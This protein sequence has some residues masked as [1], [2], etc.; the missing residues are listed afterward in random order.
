MSTLYP[1]HQSVTSTLASITRAVVIEHGWRPGTDLE[2]NVAL[3]LSHSKAPPCEQ[4]HSVGKYRLDFAW[5]DRKIALEADGW[6]HRSPEGA[7]KDRR[8]DSWLRSQGW[9]VFR[10]DDEHGDYSLNDQVRRVARIVALHPLLPPPPPPPRP[11]QCE[12]E[13]RFDKRR[14]RRRRTQGRYCAQHAEVLGD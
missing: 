7:A 13:L 2:N 9:V 5:P 12:A 1:Y 10:I 3:A 8:R 11:D 4:Q 6:Y 14:C